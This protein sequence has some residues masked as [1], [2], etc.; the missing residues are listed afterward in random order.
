M[1]EPHNISICWRI[2][3]RKTLPDNAPETVAEFERQIMALVNE[4]A[5][6]ARELGMSVEAG[7]DYKVIYAAV[8]DTGP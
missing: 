5:W 8:V 7:I 4:T 1:S 2:C 6:R 3:H